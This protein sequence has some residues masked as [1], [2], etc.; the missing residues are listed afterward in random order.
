[1]RCGAHYDDYCS[2]S[3]SSSSSAYCGSLAAAA[4]AA[5]PAACITLH[6][7]ISIH[8]RSGGT[9]QKGAASAESAMCRLGKIVLGFAALILPSLKCSRRS[10]NQSAKSAEQPA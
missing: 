5:E 9:S 1:M 10:R 7:L 6:L 2:A 4:C 8:T 3:C